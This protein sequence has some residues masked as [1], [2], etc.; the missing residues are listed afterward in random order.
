MKN[1]LD[2]ITKL[3][4]KLYALIPGDVKIMVYA[5]LFTMLSAYLLLVVGDLKDLL[6]TADRYQVPAIVFAITLLGSIGAYIFKK[7]ANHGEVKLVVEG[8]VKTLD[9]LQTKIDAAQ[10]TLEKAPEDKLIKTKGFTFKGQ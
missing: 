5:P 1:F 7:A 10:T 6:A 4:S 3:I 2:E 8:D 9:T